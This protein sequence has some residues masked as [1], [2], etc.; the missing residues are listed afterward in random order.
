MIDGLKQ[1]WITLASNNA[2]DQHI[3]TS[4]W[5]VIKTNYTSKHRPYH[6]LSH[7]YPMLLQAKIIANKIDDYDAFKFSI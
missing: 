7:L 4:N 2:E 5:D 3:I 6:N 1:E